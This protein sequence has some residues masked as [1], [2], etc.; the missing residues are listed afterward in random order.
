MNEIIRALACDPKCSCRTWRIRRMDSLSV[1]I[2]VSSIYCDFQQWTQV[3]TDP[4][5][6]LLSRMP[7]FLPRRVAGIR[8]EWWPRSNRNRWPR[9]I[10]ICSRNDQLRREA[11][12]AQHQAGRGKT[13]R[14]NRLVART[15][16]PARIAALSVSVSEIPSLR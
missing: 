9:C 15:T 8:E 11:A 7:F 12:E 10:E 5:N 3:N 14:Q 13:D 16:I 6:D 1:G 4:R 2:R